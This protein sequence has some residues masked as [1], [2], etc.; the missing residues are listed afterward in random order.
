MTMRS[1]SCGRDGFPKFPDSLTPEASAKVAAMKDE[2]V[3][4]NHA[5]RNTNESSV[6]RMRNS[7]TQASARARH[8]EL[9]K[10]KDQLL[11]KACAFYFEITDTNA[12]QDLRNVVGSPADPPAAAAA[13]AAA[14]PP[15]DMSTMQKMCVAAATMALTRHTQQMPMLTDD[16]SNRLGG[17]EDRLSKLANVKEAAAENLLNDPKEY[18]NALD[19]AA[20]KLLKRKPDQVFEKAVKNYIEE[21]EEDVILESA[22]RIKQARKA[23]SEEEEEEEE[24]DDESE[25]E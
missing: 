1:G 21:Y 14:L 12:M 7:A 23:S 3:K 8:T 9:L 25:E 4:V 10:S 16:T 22:A 19:L 15:M 11:Q 5:L 20:D 17:I 13:A 24:E 2:L 18:D 6:A